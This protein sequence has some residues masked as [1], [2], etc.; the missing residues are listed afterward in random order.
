MTGHSKTNWLAL[1]GALLTALAGG[2]YVW[3]YYARHAPATWSDFDQ[4]WLG[5][6]ALVHGQDPYQVVKAHF[7]WPL[8][9]PMPALILGLP[10]VPLSL[11]GAR[12]A[13]AAI[14]AGLFAYA[15]LRERP[16]AWPLILTG[17]FLYALQRGQWSPILT[18]AALLP[19]LGLAFAAKPTIGTAVF[20]YAPSRVAFAAA[21]LLV[22]VATLWMPGWPFQWVA[23]RES[24]HNLVMP[25]L[26]PFGWVLLLAFLRWQRGEA[27]LIGLLALVPQTFSMYELVPL[28]L[29]PRDFRE[30]V[31][32]ALVFNVVYVVL[33]PLYGRPLLP[34]DVHPHYVPG[35][36]FP[37]LALAYIPALWLVLRPFPLWHRPASFGGW[38]RWRRSGW[39]FVWI[40]TFG[41]M[42]MVAIVGIYAT[43]TGLWALTHLK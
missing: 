13:F 34:S 20:A 1:R 37:T 27:R 7:P 4:I 11:Q 39:L 12:V 23:G 14:S 42:I 21:M 5:A 3:W 33:W 16:H 38:P 25:A 17:P 28:S 30:A 24:A 43:G 19:T 32:L 36:W 31:T 6:R 8:Y 35:S 40:A 2:L 18:G 22:L 15:L 9:Y 26:L 41:V 10:V 29:I